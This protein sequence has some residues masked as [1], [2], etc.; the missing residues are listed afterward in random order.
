MFSIAYRMT[1]S[2]GDAE[3]IVQDAF[4]RL[5]RAL[6]DGA[7]I[8][9]PKAYLA[10]VTT[11]LAISHL[12]SARVRREAYVGAWLPEPLVTTERGPYDDPRSAPRCPIPCRWRSSS[13]WR[14]SRRPNAPCS[15]C[16]RSS[17]TTTPRSP[18]S[19]ASPR[20]T[21]GRSPSAPGATSN[22]GKP[23][24]DASREERD[25][26]ARRFFD[27]AGGGDLGALL[28][29]LAPDVVTI[30]DGGGKGRALRESLHGPERV[31]RFCWGCSGG[32]RRRAS[33]V[34]GPGQRPAGRGGLRRRRAGGRRVRARHRRR[35]G[36]GVPRRD[37]PGQA[38]PP[39]PDLRPL[40]A[41][42]TGTYPGRHAHWFYRGH[43]RRRGRRELRRH[44]RPAAARAAEQSGQAPAR[45]RAGDGADDRG[46][47][48][49]HRVPHRD[50]PKKRP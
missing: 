35:P 12:R 21:A 11:R 38:H 15:S 24:F 31:A 18:R 46:V 50:W 27:A 43:R 10:T 1:G 44:P 25:E 36:P 17:A 42:R 32:R 39:R 4:V 28:S 6:R 45:L 9:S 48:P 37:Q 30:G 2:V 29:L 8:D 20:R 16:T 33:T 26:V 14:A 41:G 34:S 23:R 3:D 47:G 5:T 22:A 19:S 7:R 49:G 40:P 13:C